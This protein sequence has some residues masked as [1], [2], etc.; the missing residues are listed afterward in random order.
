MGSLPLS[1]SG[2]SPT[3]GFLS[4]GMP[5]PDFGFE[6]L[7]LAAELR[8]GCRGAGWKQ[9]DQL[10]DPCSMPVKEGPTMDLLVNWM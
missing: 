5:L 9:G 7:T 6:K 2:N 8:T 1:H 4:R 3:G 10:G